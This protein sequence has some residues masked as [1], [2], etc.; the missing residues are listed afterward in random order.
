SELLSI[1]RETFTA[2]L[3]PALPESLRY[4]ALMIANAMAIARREIETGEGSARAELRRLRVLFSEAPSEPDA[5][6]LRGTVADYNR[7]LVQAIRAGRY[8]SDNAALLEHLRRTAAEKLAISNP[9]A[10]SGP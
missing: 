10:L 7:R 4:T 2:Q 6:E 8:D 5:N 9:K 3:L 1:A